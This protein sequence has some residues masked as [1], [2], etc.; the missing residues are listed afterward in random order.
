M[1]HERL[2]GNILSAFYLTYDLIISIN[3]GPLVYYG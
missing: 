2:R 1:F 3:P